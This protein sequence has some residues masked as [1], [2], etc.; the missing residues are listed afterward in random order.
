MHKRGSE[1]MAKYRTAEGERYIEGDGG[2][3]WAPVDGAYVL[4]LRGLGTYT[5]EKRRRS[6]KDGTHTTGWYLYSEGG[7]EATYFGEF[8]AS[9]I[10]EA[11][12]VADDMI[13][14]AHRA[15]ASLD[16]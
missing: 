14:R 9:R 7:S 8:C 4:D 10:L 5:L 6:P 2:H 16:Y 12:D 11:V 15:S 13:F 1:T 3:G